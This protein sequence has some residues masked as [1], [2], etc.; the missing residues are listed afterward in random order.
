M[1][2]P[3]LVSKKEI[4]AKIRKGRKAN[5]K[6]I[7]TVVEI[8]LKE[9]GAIKKLANK[10]DKYFY[11]A[12]N[13]MFYRTS[14]KGRVIVTG[15]GKSGIVGRKI[16]AT[17]A[18]VGTPA[19][20]LHPAEGSHGDLGIITREDVV[21][22]ISNSGQAQEIINLLPSIKRIGAS[23]ITITSNRKSE[24]AKSSEIVLNI[25]VKKEAGP[26]GLAPT[27][28]TTVTMALGDA[29]AICLLK[30]RG[31]TKKDYA[32]FHPG[33]LLGKKL[34]LRVSDLM[35][36]GKEIPFVNIKDDIRYIVWI[37]SKKRLG[38]TVVIDK[39]GRTRGV[40]SDGDLRR[41]M[42]CEKNMFKGKASALMT[43]DY[44]KI[45]EDK[46]AVEALRIMQKNKI[47]FLLCVDKK[48]KTVGVLHIHDLLNAGI[49]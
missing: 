17:L 41:S 15:I 11:Q 45:R 9:A 3:V 19:V 1:V 4:E 49:V 34:L 5:Q 38:M 14:W 30:I 28:S 23:L 40:I 7:E 12:V 33:G 29:L 2:S 44:K 32:L 42:K 22:A 48:G 8:L 47:T 25:G 24:L 39:L 36:K 10:I 16:A 18:S 27:T 13:V 35:H 37:V 21:L 31:F 46:L 6:T 20:F 26:L 43:K